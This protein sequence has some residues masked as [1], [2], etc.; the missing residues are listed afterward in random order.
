MNPLQPLS[1]E[2]LYTACDVGRFAFTTTADLEDLS[3]GIGQMRAIEAAH[4][5]IGMRH[6]GYNL[7]VMGQPG[8]GKRTLIR[9]LLD[10][11][12]GDE[13]AYHLA[14]QAAQAELQARGT[15]GRCVVLDAANGHGLVEAVRREHAACLV[16][17]DAARLRG[18]RGFE[19]RLDEL[20]CP[21]VLTR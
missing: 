1:A 8:G 18:G 16:L 12:V 21:I 10:R 9:Q 3:D 6:A 11:R 17:P 7:Y 5:G 4:F 13:A 2:R 20:E 15:L 14:C 19:R